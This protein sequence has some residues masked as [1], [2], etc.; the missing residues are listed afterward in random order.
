MSHT[1]LTTNFFL[2]D[3]YYFQALTYLECSQKSLVQNFLGNFKKHDYVIASNWKTQRHPVPQRDCSVSF[4]KVLA[5]QYHF[6]ILLT[7][8]LCP[9]ILSEFSFTD[10]KC[11]NFLSFL[12]KKEKYSTLFHIIADNIANDS[13]VTLVSNKDCDSST[14]SSVHPN[15]IFR[16]I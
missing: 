3:L 16:L 13:L 8:V 9:L 12:K 14:D 10:K 7:S 5:D 4:P 2:V 15:S 1:Y 6:S 11:L